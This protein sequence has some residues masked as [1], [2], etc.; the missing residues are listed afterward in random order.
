VRTE[1]RAVRATSSAP[2]APIGMAMAQPVT[3]PASTTSS[4]LGL[5]WSGAGS[6]TG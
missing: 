5:W 3:S 6:A 4:T 1:V 2:T